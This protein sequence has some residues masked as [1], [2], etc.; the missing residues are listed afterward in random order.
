MKRTF[1]AVKVNP[2][3]D[4]LRMIS[5]LKSLL[6]DENI[7]WVDPANIHLTL[8]FLGDTEEKRIKILSGML[9]ERCTGFGEF[10]FTLAGAGVFKN[11]W[12]PRVIWVGIRSSEK[13][14]MLYNAI[15]EGLKREGFGIEE[16]QFRPHL[17]LGRVKSY[18][19][20]EN[21]KSVIEKYRDKQFQVVH[22]N[23][24]I[25]FESILMQTGPIYK[26]LGN[27]SLT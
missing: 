11:F 12:D 15:A 6:S 25:L 1:I 3:G 27:L 20:T 22:V 5:S 16:R 4:L 13:L 8:A 19:D 10:D 9:S 24:V 7:K 2:E 23:E 17:T 21:L 18:K 26:S 14:F